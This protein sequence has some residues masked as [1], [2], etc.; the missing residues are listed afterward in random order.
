MTENAIVILTS[1][2]DDEKLHDFL[3]KV[4]GEHL[5]LPLER[6]T[7]SVGEDEYSCIF[8][9][10]AKSL[11]VRHRRVNVGWIYNTTTKATLLKLSVQQAPQ[12]Q[13]PTK[14]WGEAQ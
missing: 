6:G 14:V 7:I 9:T 4:S 8:D 1:V 10:G 5:K 13:K 12:Q 3:I 2:L 11:E